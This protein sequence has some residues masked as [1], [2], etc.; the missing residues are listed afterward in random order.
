MGENGK[1]RFFYIIIHITFWWFLSI[2]FAPIRLLNPKDRDSDGFPICPVSGDE[3]HFGVFPRCISSVK[4]LAADCWSNSNIQ[5]TVGK[6][7]STLSFSEVLRD[8]T[9]EYVENPDQTFCNASPSIWLQILRGLEVWT[10]FGVS[11]MA[12]LRADTQR[13]F[14]SRQWSTAELGDGLAHILTDGRL[15]LPD[16]AAQLQ[17][18]CPWGKHAATQFVLSSYSSETKRRFGF[19]LDPLALHSSISLTGA[20]VVPMPSD[21]LISEPF[22]PNRSWKRPLPISRQPK[23]LIGSQWCYQNLFVWLTCWLVGKFIR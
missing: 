8:F 7:R 16:D 23:L 21:C 13:T 12:F 17:D 10:Q 2:P 14:V 6:T 18:Q 3:L 1:T 15:E 20:S 19:K 4:Q 9:Q 11:L 22:P 5:T